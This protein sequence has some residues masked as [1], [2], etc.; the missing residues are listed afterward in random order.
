MPSF[1]GMK[2]SIRGAD[3][4]ATISIDLS[5][6]ICQKLPTGRAV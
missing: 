5:P 6:Y 1:L 3:W 2:H 4:L